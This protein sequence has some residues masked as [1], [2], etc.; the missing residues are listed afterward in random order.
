MKLAASS[1]R[2]PSSGPR[3]EAPPFSYFCIHSTKQVKPNAMTRLAKQPPVLPISELREER[4][5]EIF[6]V[7]GCDD[8]SMAFDGPQQANRPG[9]QAKETRLV[10]GAHCR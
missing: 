6:G 8:V 9:K 5:A 10:S 1:T 7:W 2:I 4:S 3:M